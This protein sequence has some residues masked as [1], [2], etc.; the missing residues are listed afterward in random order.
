M[1]ILIDGYNMIAPVAPPRRGA[2]SDWLR[3]ERQ[4]L[5]HSLASQLGEPLSRQTTVVFDAAGAPTKELARLGL[6]SK[7][8]E[9]GIQIEF[10]VDHEQAD[11]RIAELINLHSSPKRLTVVSSDHRVQISAQ[12]RGATAI[13][14]EVWWDAL[15]DGRIMLA[16][17]WPPQKSSGSPASTGVLE[18]GKGP[19]DPED[20]ERWLKEFGFSDDVSPPTGKWENPFPEGYGEDLL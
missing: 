13:D 20:V 11:D 14:S 7:Y 18:S 10:S 17:A 12:R 8:V 6:E 1:L 19:V 16:I 4:R 5:I 9:Q 2:A 3:V 15:A